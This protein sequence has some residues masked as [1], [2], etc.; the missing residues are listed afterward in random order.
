MKSRGTRLKILILMIVLAVVLSIKWIRFQEASII[1][2][3]GFTYVVQ[4]GTNL[5]QLTTD[6]EKYLHLQNPFL[7]KLYARLSGDAYALKT[8]EYFLPAG[9]TTSQVFDKLVSGKVV[10]HAFTL[11]DGWNM[12]DVMSVLNKDRSIKHTL[13]RKSLRYIAKQMKL[14][15]PSPEGLLYPETY[16]FTLHSTDLSILNRAHQAMLKHLNAAWAQRQSGLP[17]KNEY[18]A[19]IVASMVEKE[20]A[21]SKERPII[22]RVILKRWKMWMPLQIDS[23]VIY[24]LEPFF[25]GKLR[26]SDLRKKTSYNTYTRY[27]L[28]PTPI[29]IPGA[30]A[31]HAALHPVSTKALYFVAKGDGSHHFSPTLAGQRKAIDRYLRKKQPTPNKGKTTS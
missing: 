4:P 30:D 8:G 18:Q 21:L 10:Y 2:A 5:D 27:G 31:I 24:G 25:S 23:T 9:S 13:K 17:Y 28:P 7:F 22:A 29:A 1:P 11:V 20:S 14:K 3:G 12:Y 19:L 26:R 15:H 6:F 16:Y